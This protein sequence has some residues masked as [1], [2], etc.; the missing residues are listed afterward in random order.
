MDNLSAELCRLRTGD[1]DKISVHAG[2]LSWRGQTRQ[3]SNSRNLIM[4][5][6]SSSRSRGSCEPSKPILVNYFL[7]CDTLVRFSVIRVQGQPKSPHM[8]FNDYFARREH[9][10]QRHSPDEFL[11]LGLDIVKAYRYTTDRRHSSPH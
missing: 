2:I 5:R 3:R 4:T 6:T 1:D 9:S 10:S 11:S 7:F 8:F